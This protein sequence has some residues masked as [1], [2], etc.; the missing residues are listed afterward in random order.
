MP[1]ILKTDLRDCLFHYE[2]IPP[3]FSMEQPE[4]PEQGVHRASF[5][6]SESKGQDQVEPRQPAGY[7]RRMP[8]AL[9]IACLGAGNMAEALI[10]GML[11]SGLVDPACLRVT[12]ISSTRLQYFQKTFSVNSI[13]GNTEAVQWGDIILL[14]VKPQ[15]MDQVL[16]EIHTHLIPDHIVLS[17]A[18]GYPIK[19]I[20]GH[21]G[22]GTPILR[23]MPNTPSILQEGVTALAAGP[24]VTPEQIR[25]AQ[26]IFESVGKVVMVEESLMDA[27]TGLSGSGPAYVY[28]FIDALTDAGVL[29]GLPR[30]AAQVLAT[31]TVLGAA[32]MVEETGAHPALLKDRVT[33]P[34][35]TTISGIRELEANGFRGTVMKAVEAAT[36]R[37]CELGSP[38]Q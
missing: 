13:S 10:G 33:S 6:E 16:R 38:P 20:Q 28:V 12:D 8:V 15:I 21:V 18:A 25:L 11:K 3:V 26:T 37:S 32:R 19:R 4:K 31:R 17:V 24:L 36:R 29:M 34:G 35:G 30:E 5:D 22:S 7:T 23:A 2:T 14:C 27:V 1:E 9:K